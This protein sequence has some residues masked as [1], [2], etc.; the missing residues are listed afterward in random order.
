MLALLRRVTVFLIGLAA[1]VSTHSFVCSQAK[2]QVPDLICVAGEEIVIPV[3]LFDGSEISAIHFDLELDQGIVGGQF[4]Q[5][6]RGSLLRDH[7]LAI[8]AHDG[9]LTA[10][11]SSASSATFSSNQGTLFLIRRTVSGLL[12]NDTRLPVI[13][14]RVKASDSRGNSVLIE[15]SSGEIRVGPGKSEPVRGTSDLYFPQI[16][17]G[18]YPGGKFRTLLIL[19]DLAGVRTEAVASFF[20][21]SGAPFFLRMA[22]GR[23]GSE[24]GFTLEPFATT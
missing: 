9:G 17:D 6:I 16:A 3:L 8:R 20:N 1:V 4:T 10:L 13:L 12:P 14:S 15:V 7:S 22:D 24:F 2:I 21:S 23:M 11:V 5:N 19:V 18:I